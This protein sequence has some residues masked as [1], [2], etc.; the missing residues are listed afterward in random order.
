MHRSV[1]DGCAELIFHYKGAFTELANGENIEQS[2]SMI[3]AQSTQ[4]AFSQRV[5]L[6]FLTLICIRSLFLYFFRYRLLS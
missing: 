2:F 3:H 1:A 6:V 5:A 4:Q